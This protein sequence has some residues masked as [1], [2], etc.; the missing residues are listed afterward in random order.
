MSSEW[1]AAWAKA[2]ASTLFEPWPAVKARTSKGKST[3]L[4]RWGGYDV[5]TYWG[6][7]GRE[8]GILLVDERR[9]ETGIFP[10]AG[11]PP[12]PEGKVW[13]DGALAVARVLGLFAEEFKHGPYG[14]LRDPETGC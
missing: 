9:Y 7:I 1:P 12:R 8:I 3:F 2:D 4:G 11:I 14:R 13:V 6:G 10:L 5:R